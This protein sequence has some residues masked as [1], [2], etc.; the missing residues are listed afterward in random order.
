[1]PQVPL[2]FKLLGYEEEPWGPIPSY[3]PPLLDQPLM[4]GAE[5]ESAGPAIPAG[6]VPL[7]EAFPAMP[8]CFTRTP[9]E[10]LPIAGRYT[11]DSLMARPIPTWGV[12]DSERIQPSIYAHEDTPET[13]DMATN[14][15]RSLRGT[16]LL[17]DRWLPRREYWQVRFGITCDAPGHGK[18]E[19]GGRREGGGGVVSRCLAL[20]SS[21]C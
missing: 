18:L 13:H 1:M 12:R 21:C 20:P 10:S 5:E 19:D 2:K 11:D 4:E 6:I 15:C 7:P 17:S 9:Y 16:P 3:L 14:S 8:G